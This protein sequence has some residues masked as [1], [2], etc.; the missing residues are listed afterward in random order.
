[1]IKRWNG[2]YHPDKKLEK[3]LIFADN[4]HQ[5]MKI[6]KFALSFGHYMSVALWMEP[7]LQGADVPTSVDGAFASASTGNTIL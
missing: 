4:F 1:M 5:I 6:C 7:C 2:M 3:R